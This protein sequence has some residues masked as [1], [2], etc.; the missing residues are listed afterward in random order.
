MKRS[1]LAAAVAAWLALPVPVATQS[2]PILYV[3]GTSH[4]DSQ[5]NW[6][7][8]DSIRRYVPAT[9]FENFDRFE[10]YPNYVFSY[11]GAIH[12]MWFKE[13]YPEE[14]AKVQKYV[15]ADRWKIAGNWINAVDVNVPAPESLMRHALYAK[16]FFRQEFG[17]VGRDVYLP[18]CFGFGFALPSI[19][20]HS[21]LDA[22]TTQK[23]T[24]GS[25]YGIPFPV[26]RWKGTDGSE[27]IAALNPGAY[28]T[29][30]D[31][32]ISVD[33][34]WSNDP[35]PLGNG[36]SVIY[37]LF[38]VGDIGGAPTAESVEWLEKSLA[39]KNGAVEIRNA[40]VDQLA[41]DLTPQEKAALPVYEGEL[42]MKTHG[43]GTHTS[44][45][46]MKTFNREN[47]RLADAAERASVAAGW[48]TGLPYPGARLRDAWTRVLWHHFHDDLTGT[49]IPQAYQFSWNDELVSLNQFAG[50]MTSAASS[51]S[52]ILDTNVVGVPLVVY[53]PVALGRRDAVE[54]TVDFTGVTS[55][56][57][58]SVSVQDRVTQRAVPS[59]ILERQG[60]R[61]RILFMADM[62]SVGFKV[63]NAV[64][65]ATSISAS[66]AAA[67]VS[68]GA[69]LRVTSNSLANA[70][71]Q[72]KIDANGDIASVMD[73]DAKRELLKAPIRL[74]M[75]DNPSPDKPA[76]RILYETVTAPVRE[77][78]GAASSALPS[79]RPVVKVIERGPVR[80]ALE[81]T[82]KAA[83]STIVQ[84]IMLTD[85]GDRI[86]VENN[87]DWK[88]TNTLLK[89]SF[90]FAASNPK[91]TY[92]LGLGTISRGNNTA[93]AYEVPAQWWADLTDTGG[94]FGAAVLSDSKYGWDKPSDNVLRLT[95]LH[96]PKAGAWPRPF[97]QSSQ[98][99]GKHRFT[100]SV[101]GHA[102]DWRA[103]D[104]P[105]RAARLNQPLIAFQSP[106]HPGRARVFS[107][108][109]LEDA[110]DQVAIRAL[111]IAEDTDEIV[112][113]VQELWGRPA[114]TRLSLAGAILS[115][116]EINAA[117]EPVGPISAH[118]GKLDIT[119]SPYQPRTFAVRLAPSPVSPP[120]ASAA[121]GV[122]VTLPFNL[123]GISLDTNRAD[124]N[125]D[126]NGLT[127]AGELWPAEIALNGLAFKLGSS[128]PA[129]KNVVVPNGQSI[130]LPAGSFNRVY[131]LASAVDGD[132]TESLK[133]EIPQ[134]SR[135]FARD[136]GGADAAARV[137]PAQVRMTTVSMLPAAKIREWQGPVGQWYSPLKDTRMLR[138]VV[139][140]EIPR[141]TWLEGPIANDMVT[142]FD[143]VTG[144][145]SGIELIRPAF[146][147]RDEIAWVGT[148]RHA[149]DGNQIYIPSYIF[150]YGFDVPA[151]ATAIRLPMNDKLRIFAITAVREPRGVV[152]ARA[153]Y[154]A[155]LPIR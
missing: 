99:L 115:A 133:F 36:R 53:N 103:G 125:F 110:A 27:V 59:Q 153:L 87:I 96:T 114:R 101:A 78:V 149:A 62:P 25:S 45:S 57:P 124:G 141:Q 139:V 137:D 70:R 69:A 58:V 34:K 145:V 13:Y 131:V 65:L 94:A 31:S 28:V 7:V 119:L 46:A 128:A 142:K 42:T 100:Y 83:G 75:R 6:T 41:K 82:R 30:I 15:A 74:E 77:Y 95:L 64:P 4:L 138:E 10:K 91:A 121:H 23:L 72:V 71:Y 40:S 60:R 44:Q 144:L 108:A 112:V 37:R 86:D 73:K 126:G 104:V 12:Y 66:S 29:K 113:R 117:E 143:P 11:E 1:V 85:G 116:R 56:V 135:D 136:I 107:L 150:L 140:P 32:D 9:F 48:L 68:A 79:G 90:P 88:S 55:R 38:G 102:S 89:A 5:W 152:P 52:S 3:V 76:W 63:Y 146:V 54:A 109:S 47:E 61:F 111:K 97:Y 20:K 127:L 118:D 120:P 130:P 122:P 39:N 132:I 155:D 106:A 129:Q 148:H 50:V 81:I 80:V 19:A 105:M 16:R 33:P 24:W 22:F 151:R 98:D 154:A 84:K 14:W 147:K 51:V 43:V 67:V 8:Q 134:S 21:G 35:T 18:D 26:G 49:S 92:D 123:D 17:K 2:K 93:D